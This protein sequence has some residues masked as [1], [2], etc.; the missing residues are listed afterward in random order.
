MNAESISDWVREFTPTFAC[1]DLLECVHARRPRDATAE[2]LGDLV[3]RSPREIEPALHHLTSR[4]VLARREGTD[5]VP[6]YSY[7]PSPE[8]AERVDWMLRRLPQHDV[9]LQV[10]TTILSVNAQTAERG[11]RTGFFSQLPSRKR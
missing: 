1:W 11:E 6:V 5:G 10:V 9:R 2:S 3:G 4:G 7:E 8:L